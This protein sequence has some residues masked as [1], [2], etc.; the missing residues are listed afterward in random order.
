MR[1]FPFAAERISGRTLH[2]LYLS[3][4]LLEPDPKLIRRIDNSLVLQE[5]VRVIAFLH[6]SWQSRGLVHHPRGLRR[7]F[8]AVEKKPRLTSQDSRHSSKSRPLMVALEHVEDLVQRQ[9]LW[10][11]FSFRWSNSTPLRRLVILREQMG[12]PYLDDAE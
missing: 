5:F 3:A 2:F 10:G 1:L 9:H 6:P 8:V 12:S 7:T 4:V 11:D